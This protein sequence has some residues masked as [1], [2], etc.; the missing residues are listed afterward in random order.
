VGL[1]KYPLSH[2]EQYNLVPSVVHARHPVEPEDNA[3]L[4][5]GQVV[6]TKPLKES[7]LVHA[8]AVQVRQLD[9]QATQL[10]EFSLYP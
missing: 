4:H 7:Q 3:P 8:E 10:P 9:P 1:R 6:P 5:R 2:F